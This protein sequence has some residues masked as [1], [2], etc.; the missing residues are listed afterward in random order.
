[1]SDD[2]SRNSDTG[3]NTGATQ[4]ASPENASTLTLGEAEVRQFY[5]T[6]RYAVMAAAGVAIGLLLL[7]QLLAPMRNGAP[8]TLQHLLGG[9]GLFTATSLV[10]AVY[11]A[12]QAA[13]RVMLT[14]QAITRTIPLGAA[15]TVELRQLMSVSE[16]GRAGNALILLYHPLRDDGLLELDD[17]RSL[18]LPA[19]QGQDE[20]RTYL[21]ARVPA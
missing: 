7:W 2:Q 13:T 6:A 16:S 1:M 20:L 4:D 15:Q 10:L 18:V 21:E 19:L 3:Q 9:E 11:F 5:P 12:R 17:V 14:K 8:F